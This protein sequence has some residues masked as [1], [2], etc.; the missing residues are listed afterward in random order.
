MNSTASF[1]VKNKTNKHKIANILEYEV[2]NFH[3]QTRYILD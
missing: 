2:L 1:Q 3:N